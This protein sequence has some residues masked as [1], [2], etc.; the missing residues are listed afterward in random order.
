MG[1]KHYSKAIRNEAVLFYERGRSF[2]ETRAKYGMAESTFFE[3]KK[4]FDQEHPLYEPAGGSTKAARNAQLHLE[5]LA[6]ELEVVRQCPCGINAS[7]DDKIGA[8]N[9][10]KRKILH[11]CAV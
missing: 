1:Q 10:L 9:A 3:W 2:A 8:I 11:P 4:R 7:I 5:K 6:L